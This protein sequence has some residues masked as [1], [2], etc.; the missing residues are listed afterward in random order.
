VTV[1]GA[2]SEWTTNIEMYVGR[3]GNGTLTIDAGG[4][5]ISPSVF[6]GYGAKGTATVTGA[7]STWTN[8]GQLTVGTWGDGTLTIEAGGQVTSQGGTLGYGMSFVT[9][10]PNWVGRVTVRG[11]GSKWNSGPLRVGVDGMGTLT[12]EAGGQVSSTSSIVG[13][14][15]PFDRNSVVV[16]GA[17][18]KW[19][20]SGSLAVGR[21]GQ[22][23]LSITGAGLVTVGG[24]LTID[25]NDARD[26]YEDS[27]INMATGGMLALRGDAD[28]SLSQFLGLVGGLDNIRYWDATLADWSPLTAATHG[29]DYTLSYLTEGDLSGYTLLT[30]GR[31]GDFDNDGDVDGGDFLTWQRGGSPTPLSAAGLAAWQA[32]FGTAATA[33]TGAV[34]EPTTWLLA[35][36][37]CL[38]GLVRRRRN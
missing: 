11:A 10:D 4:Q 30:V 19:T 32:G 6:L 16:T 37:C 25:G 26:L 23:A 3:S 9:P 21:F 15:T 20:N 35:A 24:T 33:N 17:G 12:I 34:P 22:A 36:S 18:S 38:Y 13:E 31:A 29:D 2:G 28:E 1:T 27:F 5:V 7:G 8:N 14:Q